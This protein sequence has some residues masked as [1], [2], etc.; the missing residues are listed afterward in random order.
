MFF[1]R[2]S[3]WRWILN[4]DIKICWNYGF[5]KSIYHWLIILKLSVDLSLVIFKNH[6]PRHFYF[7]GL[8]V[9]HYSVRFLMASQSSRL[10][11]YYLNRFLPLLF[12]SA[13]L[14]LFFTLPFLWCRFIRLFFCNWLCVLLY[15]WHTFMR[16]SLQIN[17]LLEKLIEQDNKKMS[18]CKLITKL[19]KIKK[20]L[21]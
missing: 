4:T 18:W 7:Q 21:K 6:F 10:C 8:I 12:L 5:N 14:N 20:K 9:A 15:L 2:N 17:F 1:T 19:I 13:F 11:V 16:Q 3:A